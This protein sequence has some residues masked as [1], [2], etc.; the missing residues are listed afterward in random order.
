MAEEM[1]RAVRL[2]ALA[3]LLE[4]EA[5]EQ[6]AGLAQVLAEGVQEFEDG[7]VKAWVLEQVGSSLGVV[8]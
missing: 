3:Q 1:T 8:L 4:A 5:R 7:P 2:D 6:S